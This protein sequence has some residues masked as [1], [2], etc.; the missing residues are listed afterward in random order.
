[1]RSRSSS[2]RDHLLKWFPRKLHIESVWAEF[3]FFTPGYGSGWSQ[4]DSLEAPAVI[5][6]LEH[7]AAGEVRQVHFTGSVIRVPNPYSESCQSCDFYWTHHF[8]PPA[9][10]DK[11]ANP[12]DNMG[13]QEKVWEGTPRGTHP[14]SGSPWTKSPRHSSGDASELAASLHLLTM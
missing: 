9:V 11:T 12:V 4:V 7:S 6:G 5:P 3:D 2:T 13:D 14:A 8:A 10:S 1:M